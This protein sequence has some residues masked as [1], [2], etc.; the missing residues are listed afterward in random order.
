[1]QIIDFDRKG[2]VVRFYI[3]KN[4]REATGDDWDDAQLRIHV[5]LEQYMTNM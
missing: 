5:M 2:N 1:M 4:A 3:G